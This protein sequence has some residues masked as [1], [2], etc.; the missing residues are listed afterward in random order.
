MKDTELK[1]T[2]RT[3]PPALLLGPTD[4]DPPPNTPEAETRVAGGGCLGGPSTGPFSLAPS[5]PH[6]RN[7]VPRRGGAC[8]VSDSDRRAGPGLILA[9]VRRRLGSQGSTRIAASTRKV[10]VQLG[11]QRHCTRPGRLVRTLDVVL[12]T[13]TLRPQ[14]LLTQSHSRQNYCGA[15][16]QTPQD[17]TTG[18]AERPP[19]ASHRR[20]EL[21]GG[22]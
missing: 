12:T 7:H 11:L 17:N 13:V 5:C 16:C 8:Q 3:N 19:A 1:D 6:G 20:W 21:G 4:I 15:D 14:S 10:T 9:G 18:C 22:G 2:A